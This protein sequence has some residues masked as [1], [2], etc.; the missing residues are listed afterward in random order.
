MTDPANDDRIF[1]DK[2][3]HHHA[4]LPE[5]I[6]QSKLTIEES[7]ELLRRM[8]EIAQVEIKALTPQFLA[9]PGDA[10]RVAFRLGGPG[11]GETRPPASWHLA[12]M[13]PPPGVGD[14][15]YRLD[16]PNGRTHA[17]PRGRRDAF[18]HQS[19]PAV[20]R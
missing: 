16:R 7:K 15:P 18:D 14:L 3:R 19:V 12:Q 13:A 10:R 11:G 2:V 6:R 20:R 1:L 4:A 8:D 5:Q 17:V 9:S